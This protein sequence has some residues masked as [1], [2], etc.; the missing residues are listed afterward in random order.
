MISNGKYKY[1]EIEN[2]SISETNPYKRLLDDSLRLYLRHNLTLEAYLDILKLLQAFPGNTFNFPT[3]KFKLFQTFPGSMNI[4]NH[5][6]CNDC[7]KY[8]EH[9]SNSE[10]YSCSRCQK[11]LYP[12]KDGYFQYISFKAQL[13]QQITKH[14]TIITDYMTECNGNRNDLQDCHDGRLNVKK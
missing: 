2:F 8:T 9:S 14:W 10:L 1:A 3:T 7:K 13:K 12:K 11:E 4:Y 6:K 5:V